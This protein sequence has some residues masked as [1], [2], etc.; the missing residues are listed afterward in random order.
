MIN[1]CGLLNTNLALDQIESPLALD[2]LSMGI[3][4]NL[5]P[6]DSRHLACSYSHIPN[7]LLHV[8]IFLVLEKYKIK[9][10]GNNN[11]SVYSLVY[12]V[13]FNICI[14]KILKENYSNA[15]NIVLN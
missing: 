4:K 1:Q 12:I 3:Q 6:L 14:P 2:F 10:N 15:M 9:V 5:F 8:V 7:V 11:Y 13:L